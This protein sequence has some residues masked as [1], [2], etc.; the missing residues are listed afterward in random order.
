M[1]QEG[2]IGTSR[3][4]LLSNAA[5]TQAIITAVDD[6]PNLTRGPRRI[7]E[8]LALKGIQV[9]RCVLP[10]LCP[11]CDPFSFSCC[12]CSDKVTQVMQD[13]A[14]E[15]FQQRAP[16]RKVIHRTALVSPGPNDEWS[17]DG[18]DKLAKLGFEIYG[19]RDKFSGKFLWYRVVP[20]NR[21]AAVVGVILL[22]CIQKYKSKAYDYWFSRCSLL[23][24]EIP[25]QGSTDRGSEV[26]DAFS[27]HTTLR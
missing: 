8:A 1:R 10:L 22:E 25:I 17:M 4:P 11:F 14:R 19:I 27:I 5:Q 21:Y 3:N 13:Y 18:H 6:D 23:S 26:R 20:S 24:A 15:G 9:P 12:G 2:H 16:G 7:K